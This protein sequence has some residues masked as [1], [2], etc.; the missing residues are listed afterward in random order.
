LIFRPL[1]LSSFRISIATN[2]TDECDGKY[3][4]LPGSHFLEFLNK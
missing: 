1:A 2:Q 4:Q 3:Q